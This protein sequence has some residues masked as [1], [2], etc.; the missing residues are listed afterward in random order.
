[1]RGCACASFFSTGRLRLGVVCAFLPELFFTAFGFPFGITQVFPSALLLVFCSVAFFFFVMALCLLRPL[2]NS[3]NLRCGRLH[4]GIRRHDLQ[5]LVADVLL[6]RLQ[7]G[8]VLLL[9]I[10]RGAQKLVVAD[11]SGGGVGARG[12]EHCRRVPLL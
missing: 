9:S 4:G 6:E 1:M 12:D 8:L 3:E 5:V 7:G 10:G 2:V 11:A